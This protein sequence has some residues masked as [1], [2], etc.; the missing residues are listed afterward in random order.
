M[1]RDHY[2]NETIKELREAAGLTQEQL[3]ERVGAHWGTISR[4]ESGASCSF[5]LLCKLAD[6]FEIDWRNLIRMDGE[7]EQEFSAAA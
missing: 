2:K 6:A 4:V 3:A 5:S 7:A 1:T